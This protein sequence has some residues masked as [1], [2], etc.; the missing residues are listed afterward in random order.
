MTIRMTMTFTAKQVCSAVPIPQG[1]LNSWAHAGLL[2]DL[3]GAETTAGRAR[4]FTL[5]DVFFLAILRQLLDFGVSSRYAK[6]WSEECVYQMR[7]HG[8]DATEMSVRIYQDEMQISLN[9]IAARPNEFIRLVIY[10]WRI[11]DG[12]EARLTVVLPRAQ[13]RPRDQSA[14]SLVPQTVPK[15]EPPS[16]GGSD[17]DDVTD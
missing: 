2:R 13:R 7:R 6:P 8:K 17:I 4:R 16:D 9:N 12:L 10:P 11:V 15:S 3:S 14:A 1:T 5:D